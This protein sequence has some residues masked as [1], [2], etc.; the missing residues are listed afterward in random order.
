MIP[1]HVIHCS[2]P[3]ARNAALLADGCAKD[4]PN[5]GGLSVWMSKWILQSQ[6]P[7]VNTVPILQILV[8][9]SMHDSARTSL[10]S[11]TQSD[12]VS[13]VMH[14]LQ[15]TVAIQSLML[16]LI[17]SHGSVLWTEVEYRSK[18]S[19]RSQCKC[20][21]PEVENKA[22]RNIELGKGSQT[23]KLN[24]KTNLQ[25]KTKRHIPFLMLALDWGHS[26]SRV[27]KVD[28]YEMRVQSGKPML[29]FFVVGLRTVA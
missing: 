22:T 19:K 7:C 24:W 23:C 25:N 3:F 21:H 9:I 12:F 2:M 27:I 18:V 17:H 20:Y 6:V 13:H 28:T 29:L 5:E 11:H 14:N 15:S 26:E 16:A 10:P 8:H 1:G 4:K